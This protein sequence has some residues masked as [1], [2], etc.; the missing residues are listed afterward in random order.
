[1]AQQRRIIKEEEWSSGE[2]GKK[3]GFPEWE[4]ST[5]LGGI[6]VTV[7]YSSSVYSRETDEHVRQE[8]GWCLMHVIVSRNMTA[9]HYFLFQSPSVYW[10]TLSVRPQ[11]CLFPLHMLHFIWVLIIWIIEQKKRSYKMWVRNEVKSHL[12]LPEMNYTQPPPKNNWDDGRTAA[13]LAEPSTSMKMK[14]DSFSRTL[15]CSGNGN[16]WY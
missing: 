16:P 10:N 12:Y 11:P 13:K 15:A 2:R 5:V 14:F 7:L 8:D 1:M 9:F 4:A 3:R 6:V